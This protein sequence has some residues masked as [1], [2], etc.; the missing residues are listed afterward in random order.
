MNMDFQDGYCDG[1]AGAGMQDR[2]DISYEH[3]DYG[4]QQ[5][6]LDRKTMLTRNERQPRST[7]GFTTLEEAFAQGVF[8]DAVND[9]KLDAFAL[10]AEGMGDGDA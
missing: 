1:L 10:W 5:G 3:Y 6:S 8:G 9:D 2:Y 7:E 4:F